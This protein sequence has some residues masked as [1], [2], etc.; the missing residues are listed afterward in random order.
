MG[1]GEPAVQ[2][3][4][5]QGMSCGDLAP[6]PL[7][8]HGYRGGR[9]VVRNGELAFFWTVGIILCSKSSFLPFGTGCSLLSPSLPSGA[10]S[11]HAG[12][13][14]RPREQE[15]SHPEGHAGLDFG[16]RPARRYF[17]GDVKGPRFLSCPECWLHASTCSHISPTRSCGLCRRPYNCGCDRT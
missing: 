7:S 10:S 5:K 13:D 17:V 2:R 16:S 6:I 11:G 8:R 14:R 9:I 15:R 3:V 12:Y 4:A 1:R